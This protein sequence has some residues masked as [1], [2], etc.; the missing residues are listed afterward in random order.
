[1]AFRPLALTD[2]AASGGG[3][4]FVWALANEGIVAA[5]SANEKSEVANFMSGKQ[6]FYSRP[7]LDNKPER[8]LTMESRARG[9]G[10]VA[11]GFGRGALA[12]LSSTGWKRSSP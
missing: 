8:P 12:V 11:R 3:P 9:H 5:M 1:M 2:D 4:G 6:S 7:I 10:A